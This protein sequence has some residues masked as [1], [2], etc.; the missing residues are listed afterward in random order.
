M[1]SS[2]KKDKFMNSLKFVI[3]DLF[4]LNEQIGAVVSEIAIR[5]T[6]NDY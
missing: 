4:L 2:T 3:E 1:R 6:K 5:K